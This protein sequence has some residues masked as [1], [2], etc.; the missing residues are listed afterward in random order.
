MGVTLGSHGSDP[1]IYSPP[2]SSVHGILQAR[3]LELPWSYM[4]HTGFESALNLLSRLSSLKFSLPVDLAV[5]QLK[6][7]KDAF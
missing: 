1:W 2:V 4:A 5:R 7:I 3:L 6:N